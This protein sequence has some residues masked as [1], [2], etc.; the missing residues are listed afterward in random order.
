M[1]FYLHRYQL[2]SVHVYNLHGP[3]CMLKVS[4]HAH[5]ELFGILSLQRQLSAWR[6]LHSQLPKRGRRDQRPCPPGQP[7]L[8]AAW[9]PQEFP[10][11]LY[12]TLLLHLLILQADC[13]LSPAASREPEATVQEGYHSYIW[14]RE[15]RHPTWTEQRND[16]FCTHVPILYIKLK[17]RMFF[18]I[19]S[20]LH[21]LTTILMLQGY[22][23]V[24]WEMYLQYLNGIF[25]SFFTFTCC[26]VLLRD[27]VQCLEEMSAKK[28]AN[29]SINLFLHTVGS[30]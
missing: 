17:C 9:E 3:L 27:V 16:T 14:A 1:P 23:S 22:L 13:A 4:G 11:T 20:L 7:T 2:S 21:V 15:N 6:S 18:G 30:L 29:V 24:F 12:F 19:Y 26:W 5:I 25:C 8:Q 10:I 28:M